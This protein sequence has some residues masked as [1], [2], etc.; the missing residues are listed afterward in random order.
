MDVLVLTPLKPRLFK[1][2]TNLEF[3]LVAR[4]RFLFSWGGFEGIGRVGVP[5]EVDPAFGWIDGAVSAAR[6]FAGR[7]REAGDGVADHLA[8][9][10]AEAADRVSHE[11]DLRDVVSA[12]AGAAEALARA[13]LTLDGNAVVGIQTEIRGPVTGR[14]MISSSVCGLE[15]VLEFHREFSKAGAVDRRASLRCGEERPGCAMYVWDGRP[16][17]RQA[18]RGEREGREGPSEA[19]EDGACRRAGVR[20]RW[21]VR[22]AVLYAGARL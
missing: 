9:T 5:G 7:E 4:V 16:D 18:S 20:C 12:E 22:V 2:Y 10:A 11:K 3:A 17:G 8:L 14:V 19:F 21:R 1:D 15:F 13:E 6:S